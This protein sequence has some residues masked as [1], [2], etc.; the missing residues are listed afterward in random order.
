[1]RRQMLFSSF[2]LSKAIAASLER[3]E[4]W[5][6]LL[7][8]GRCWRYVCLLQKLLTSTE[9]SWNVSP[10]GLEKPFWAVTFKI[11]YWPSSLPRTHW[12]LAIR[13]VHTPNNLPVSYIQTQLLCYSLNRFIHASEIQAALLIIFRVG[14]SFQRSAH[15]NINASWS[16]PSDGLT[17]L[18]LFKRGKHA[19]TVRR[20]RE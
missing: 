20:T 12:S 19:S 6:Q 15:R 18:P 10:P 4:M 3:L 1:M 13:T 9:K 2:V 14:F 11:K 16:P 17:N 8:V 5:K 7:F